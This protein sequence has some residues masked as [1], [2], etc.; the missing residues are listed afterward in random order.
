MSALRAVLAPS[1][2]VLAAVL[3]AGIVTLWVMLSWQLESLVGVQDPDLEAQRRYYLM[4]VVPNLVSGAATVAIVG[5]LIGLPL[6]IGA[7]LA[8]LPSPH[9]TRPA[10]TTP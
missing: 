2:L 5:P 1:V 8:A 3:L 6:V 7:R 9:G 10:A 4:A